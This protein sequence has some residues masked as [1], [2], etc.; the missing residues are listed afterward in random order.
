MESASGGSAVLFV[1]V[2]FAD[3]SSLGGGKGISRPVPLVKVE[4]P[5]PLFLEGVSMIYV[6]PLGYSP[7]VLILP[8]R[9]NRGISCPFQV[10]ALSVL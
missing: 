7:T 6:V 5:V 8:S 10:V 3:S 9:R 2:L 1:R 4:L